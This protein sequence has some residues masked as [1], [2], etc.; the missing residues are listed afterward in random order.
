MKLIDE[1]GRLFGKISVIDVAVILAVAVMGA[2]LYVKTNERDITSTARPDDVIVFQV[3]I[4][5]VRTYTADF[6]R[7]GDLFFEDGA[8]S[9]GALGEITAVEVLPGTKAGE[10]ENDGT[11]DQEAPAEDCV[12]LLLTVK[13]SGRAADGY[14][15]LNRIYPLGVNAKRNFCT[16]YAYLPGT[17]WDILS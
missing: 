12:N 5:E 6:V 14:Y 4:P 10:F 8:D 11:I 3:M 7:V 1:N 2:A 9:G 13:G 15:M 16:K 17:V